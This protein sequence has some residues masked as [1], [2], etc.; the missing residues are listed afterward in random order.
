M[1]VYCN[2]CDW[3]Q[4]DFYDQNYNPVKSLKDWDDYLYGDKH[5]RLDEVFSDDPEFV[6]MNGRIYTR[7]LIAREYQKYAKRI[8]NMRW[9]TYEDFK[10]DPDKKCPMCGSKEL[11]ID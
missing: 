6:S 4:D 3:H 7:E 11:N 8:Q 1:F 2:A 5:D 9:M 10:N